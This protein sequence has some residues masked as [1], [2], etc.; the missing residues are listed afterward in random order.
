MGK[1]F[2]ASEALSAGLLTRH[3]LQ[4]KYRKVH[5]N[6]YAPKDLALTAHT[7]AEAA[8]LWSGRSATLAGYSAAA[9]LGSR[10]LP[11]DAPAE[12]ARVRYPSPTGIRVHSGALAH[13]EVT[14]IGA[15]DCT[16][17]ARTCYD[18]GRARPMDT[19]IIRIDALLNTTGVPLEHV[20]SIT[21]R[22]PGARGI[23][24]LRK[25]LELVDAGAESPQETRLR[26]LL[27]RSGL[28]RPTTQIPVGRRRV[29]MGWP[30]WRVG[31]EYDGEH[32]WSDPQAYAADIERLDF[33]AA[34]GWAIVRVSAV[35][36]RYRQAAIVDRA[37][38]A[39]ELAGYRADTTGCGA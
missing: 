6:V 34:Q 20:T 33:L 9:M 14:V 23:R 7:R 16:T 38:R 2:L 1:I 8:W 13:D 26:L 30:Q 35:Q 25:V 24:G 11:D 29:D 5:Q 22:Y 37:R 27:I 3:S 17:V 31:V 19:G 39:L 36:L 21:E 18:I 15:M 4:T 12:L 32:H 10:W 28:P